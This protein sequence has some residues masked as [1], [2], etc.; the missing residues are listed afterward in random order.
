M[1]SSIIQARVE[2]TR[3]LPKSHHFQYDLYVYLLDLDELPDLNRSVRLFGLNRHQVV[4]LFDRDYLQDEPGSI[5]EKLL[6]LLTGHGIAA[7]DVGR[8]LLATSARYV[9]SVFN[10]VS[11]YFVFAPDRSLTCCVAEVNNTFGEKHVYPL[12]VQDNEEPFPARFHAAKAFHVSPFFDRT[13]TYR[14][15]FDDPWTRLAV[16]IRLEKDEQTVF[17]ASL[18]QT[19]PAREL[20]SRNLVTTLLRHPLTARLTFPRILAQ[21]ARLSLGRKL[22]TY[23]K[24]EPISPMT[25]RT[26]GKKP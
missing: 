26:K 3:H 4:S 13:G 5:R 2:H 18:T 11:F 25:L 9:N 19:A 16:Q 12:L 23:T 21:A 1:V 8:V 17:E 15:E 24:P 10:P 20:N 22:P 7:S 6:D 14:F